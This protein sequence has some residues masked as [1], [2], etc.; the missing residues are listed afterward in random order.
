M[1]RNMIEAATHFLTDL[2]NDNVE[3]ID[4]P[5]G[6]VYP[7]R[8]GL[9][10]NQ[11]YAR[12]ILCNAE[13]LAVVNQNIINDLKDHDPAHDGLVIANIDRDE[14]NEYTHELFCLEPSGYFS[15]YRV[16]STR[17]DNGKVTYTFSELD[18]KKSEK[19]WHFRTTYAELDNSATHH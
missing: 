2:L 15:I 5:E 14:N 3:G 12:L 8:Y 11:G 16:Q 17:E 4:D 13:S 6:L 7:Q 1:S 9:A 18:E 19:F 10:L